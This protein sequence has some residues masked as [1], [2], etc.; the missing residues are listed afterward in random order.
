MSKLISVSV[1][2]LLI[3][4]V[5]NSCST[6]PSRD[7]LAGAS[8]IGEASDLFVFV[9]IKHNRV[10]LSRILP[11]NRYLE[12]ALDRTEYIYA[13]VKVKNK[14]MTDVQVEASRHT[15]K[16]V[17]EKEAEDETSIEGSEAVAIEAPSDAHITEEKKRAMLPVTSSSDVA[18]NSSIV[19][20]SDSSESEDIFKLLSYDIC[21]IGRYPKSIAG[22][23]FKKRNGWQKQKAT[24]SGY[25]YYKKI[26][27]FDAKGV[28][29]FSFFSIPASNLALFSYNEK[30]E[31]KMENL[32]DRVNSPSPVHFGEEFEFKMQQGEEAKDIC[33]YVA[34]PQF[35]LANLLALDIDLPIDNLRVYLKRNAEKTK[36]YYNYKIILQMQN[37][38]ASFATRLLLSKLL[39]TQVRIEDDSIIIEKAKLGLDRLVKIINR[40]LNRE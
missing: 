34:N 17:S 16:D 28:P 40:V 30:N 2:L 22:L 15:S 25:K 9:P 10:L 1:T 37:E 39:K 36:E 38:T 33:I 8:I 7:S 32:L 18:V 27:A 21:A 4:C 19:S 35:F 14:K 26:D 23:V 31:A 12:K 3:L 20:G 5:L 11:Q 29:S 13:S 24:S 6:I